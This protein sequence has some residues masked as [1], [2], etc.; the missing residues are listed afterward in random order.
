M[1]TLPALPSPVVSVSEKA[2]IW[3]PLKLLSIPVGA[4][5]VAALAARHAPPGEAIGYWTGLML[6]PMLIALAAVRFKPAKQMRTFSTIF[7]VIGLVGLGSTLSSVIQNLPSAPQKTPQEI[8]REAAGTQP[9][10][11]SGTA[12]EQKV[13]RVLREFIGDILAA[14]KKHD[15]DAAPLGPS[16]ASIYTAQSFSSKK[17][18]EDVVAALKKILQVDGEMIDKF[19]RLPQEVRAR[20]DVSDLDPSDKEDV[21]RGF[22][23]GYGESRIVDTYRDVRATEEQWVAATV[24][25]YTFALQHASNIKTTD[26]KIVITEGDLLNQFNAKLKTSRDLRRQVDDANNR[27]TTLQATAMQ[28]TGISKSDLGLK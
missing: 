25:L 28:K 8:A 4:G 17:Q 1:E 19:Q 2:S 9:I 16:L 27:L 12:S 11:V 21:M 10:T 18:M 3:I 23:Q 13:D 26:K 20:V 6:L 5:L 22:Q 14:R 7:C 24:D 15:A